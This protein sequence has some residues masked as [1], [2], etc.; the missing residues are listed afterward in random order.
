LISLVVSMPT[1]TLFTS[2]A[3]VSGGTPRRASRATLH[4]LG[5]P[6]GTGRWAGPGEECRDST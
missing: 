4:R 6:I 2:G 5:K 1:L 3:L